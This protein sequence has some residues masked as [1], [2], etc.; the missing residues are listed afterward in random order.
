MTSRRFTLALTT[1]ALVVSALVGGGTANAQAK[2]ETNLKCVKGM[3]GTYPCKD[4]DLVAH[5]TADVMGGASIADV[6]GWVDPE[7]KKEYAVL[8]SNSG[9]HFF[10]LSKPDKPVYLGKLVGKAET[11]LIWQELVIVNDHAYIVCDLSPCNVQIFDLTRLRAPLPLPAQVWYPD[12][13]FPVPNAHSIDANPE[14]NH[15]FVNGTGPIVAGTPFIFDVSQPLAPVP[16][17]VTADDGYTHD[18]LCKSYA[19]P[20]KARR[21]HE[22]CFNFNED[23]IT[24]YDVSANPMMPEQ[25]S[26]TTY[27]N[28]N[29][30]HSGALSKDMSTLIS[31]DEEDE[32]TLGI[33]STLYIWD[34]SDLS[35]PEML[36]TFVAKS[37]AIDHNVYSEQDALYHANYVNGFR[38]LDLKKANRGVL[39]E[40]AY[41]DTMPIADGPDFDGVWAA[42]PYLPSGN[43]IVG[44]MSGQGMFIV[45]PHASV[46]KSLGVKRN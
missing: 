15:I 13:E 21:G 34:V 4:I 12:A 2:A 17:G 11:A 45:R 30:V 28:A 38:I 26:R 27:E 9:V 41:F 43:I 44:D 16:V 39:K 42:Y 5:V 24:I 35:K 37:G 32:A 23:T 1:A 7:T 40:V 8:G 46:F 18:S 6:Q 31:T 10:D 36:G 19:G 33:R 14:T 3:A 25:L 29:Y 22:I 20:D